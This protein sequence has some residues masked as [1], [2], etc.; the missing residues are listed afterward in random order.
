MKGSRGSKCKA[1]V[2]DHARGHLQWIGSNSQ[3][4]PEVKTKLSSDITVLI[5]HE[6]VY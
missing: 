2:D 3:Q 6:S 5:S 4:L 1:P